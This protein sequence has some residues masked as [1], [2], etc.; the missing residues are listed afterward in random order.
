M[1]VRLSVTEAFHKEG[2]P[3]FRKVISGEGKLLGEILEPA[4]VARIR[5]RALHS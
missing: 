2:D 1:K 4:A 3:V 5:R